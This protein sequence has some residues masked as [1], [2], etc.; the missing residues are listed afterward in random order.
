VK[1]SRIKRLAEDDAVAK[2][3]ENASSTLSSVSPED[4]SIVMRPENRQLFQYVLHPS[5]LS[6]LSKGYAN[7]GVALTWLL[8]CNSFLRFIVA[9][10]L[11]PLPL[12]LADIPDVKNVIR[13]STWC[14][15][16]RGEHR[17]TTEK[18]KGDLLERQTAKSPVSPINSLEE[19]RKR[20]L[21]NFISLSSRRH[22]IVGA[23]S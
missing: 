7:L 5:E 1:R 16:R 11:H 22:G 9:L 18:H 19:D 4:S 20:Q 8:W 12:E 23:W 17:K 2:K 13:C 10:I 14:A 15:G 21:N 3:I 6:I